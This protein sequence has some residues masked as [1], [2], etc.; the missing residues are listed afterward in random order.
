MQIV[1]IRHSLDRAH[2]WGLETLRERYGWDQRN[3]RIFSR[4]FKLKSAALH[5]DMSL[6]E[7]LAHSARQLAQAN[8]GL[9]G[10]V[11]LV[12]YCHAINN[13]MP[14]CSTALQDI[15]RDIFDSDA[16]TMSITMGSCCSAIMAMQWLAGL[17]EPYEHVVILTGE[18]CF[19]HLLDYADNRGLFGEITSATYLKPRGRDGLQ[20]QAT[21]SGAFDEIFLPLPH[22]T[23]DEQV[24]YDKAFIPTIGLLVQNTLQDSGLTPEDIDVVLPTHL[25]PF[26]FDRIST[27]VGIGAGRVLKHN[28]DKIGHCYCGDFFINAQT[29][30][31]EID[32]GSAP[33]RLLSFAAG[34]TGSYAAVV[35]SK[36]A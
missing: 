19:F 21:R 36:D 10:R 22:Y 14:F 16:E 12:L 25:S 24:A 32:D 18:K 28:L 3:H 1:D 8:P 17:A 29:W 23:R 6:R 34:M 26:T 33:A 30:L 9:M 11:D 15:A 4:L 7:G 31:N 2:L 5:D 35:I 20:V 27:I 13:T